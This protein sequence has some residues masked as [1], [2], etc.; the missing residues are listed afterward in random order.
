MRPSVCL[1]DDDGS[2]Y[3]IFG[4][5]NYYIAKLGDDMMSFAEPFRPVVVNNPTGPYGAKTDDKVS[6]LTTLGC[7]GSQRRNAR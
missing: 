1:Q 7:V 4:T 5:F 6:Q 2:Y 3:L